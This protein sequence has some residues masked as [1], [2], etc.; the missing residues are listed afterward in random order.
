[1]L[2]WYVETTTHFVLKRQIIAFYFRKVN[3]Q[4]LQYAYFQEPCLFIKHEPNDDYSIAN[5]PPNTF[6]KS[7][8]SANIK[9]ST[10]GRGQVV[11]AQTREIIARVIKFMHDEA[12]SFQN[13]GKPLIPLA[14]FKQ[15]VLAATGISSKTYSSVIREAR[16]IEVGLCDSFM[17]PRKQ[18]NRRKSYKKQKV[19][20][21]QDNSVVN[22]PEFVVCN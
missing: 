13:N 19:D 11:Q 7:E 14:S 17:T 15:R 2:N 12:L 20:D 3:P 21:V 16:A 5:L 22:E 8:A 18:P 1:M 10:T 4:Q 6:P 9:A